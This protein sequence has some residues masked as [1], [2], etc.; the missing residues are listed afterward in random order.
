MLKQSR[1][2]SVVYGSDYPTL[3]IPGTV[4]LMLYLCCIH[5]RRLETDLET[6]YNPS[7]FHHHT[8]D[9]VAVDARAEC[10]FCTASNFTP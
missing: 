4:I 2:F 5:T 9:V 1:T 3:R 6:G 8:Q 10:T 7:Y